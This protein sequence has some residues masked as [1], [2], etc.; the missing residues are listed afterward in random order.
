MD[1]KLFR[2]PTSPNFIRQQQPVDVR[3]IAANQSIP[4]PD[5][6]FPGW[7]APMADAR[8]VTNYQPHCQSNIP[9]GRQYP[10]VRWMQRNGEQI[11][12]MNRRISAKRMGAMY[13]L[14]PTVVPPPTDVFSCSKSECARKSTGLPG[15][16]GTERR[17]PVPD[18]FGTYMIAY[19]SP[20]DAVAT[21]TWL[22]HNYEGGRNSLRGATAMI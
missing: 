8:L 13:P 14:D 21:K 22:T 7:P 12:D 1:S 16:I 6:R 4:A 3:T 11:I 20:G 15:G 2:L 10:T 5:S 19:S 9:A 17:E 18:L